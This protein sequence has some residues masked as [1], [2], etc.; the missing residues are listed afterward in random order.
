MLDRIDAKQRRTEAE[1]WRE[2][3]QDR[4]YIL[5]AI[6]DVLSDALKIYP[7]IELPAL[8]RMAD[9]AQWGYAIS[10][11]IKA[12]NGKKFLK[13][14]YQN[15][16]GAVE[17]AVIGDIVGAAIAEFMDNRESWEGTATELLESLNE[18]PSVNV[19][20]RAWPKRPHTLTRRLNKIKAALDDYG[21]TVEFDR[22]D[23]RRIIAFANN[24]KI[25]SEASYR[26]EC[27][28]HASLEHD[29]IMTLNDAIAEEA[30][31]HKPIEHGHHDASDA[32]D[33]IISSLQKGVERQLVTEE[34]LTP[35]E[36]RIVEEYE[37]EG[38][39][40]VS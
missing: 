35:S 23:E 13:A 39:G 27:S 4:P 33:A 16:A 3:E 17:E 5:G 28:N 32:N 10:E 24:R 8:P 12:D 14:Y 29:A 34:D 2:F 7:T 1:L 26:Q 11:A 25:A 40:N 37:R 19:K 22:T 18:L 38:G 9:F 6:F 15:I 20:E 31:C 36:R 30:S 21:I